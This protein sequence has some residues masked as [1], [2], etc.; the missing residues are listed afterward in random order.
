M[1]HVFTVVGTMQT[2]ADRAKR[3]PKTRSLIVH[4][5]IGRSSSAH[6]SLFDKPYNNH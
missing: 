2:T 1:I 4:S 6:V 3:I 5:K